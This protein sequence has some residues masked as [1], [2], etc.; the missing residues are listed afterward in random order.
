MRFLWT[1]HC[2]VRFDLRVSKMGVVY[3]IACVNERVDTADHGER[4]SR[5][6]SYGEC[7]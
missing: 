4:F 2:A 5:I 1:V 6:G 7:N 3:M